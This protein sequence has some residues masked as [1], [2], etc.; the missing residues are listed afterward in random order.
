MTTV[1]VAGALA[2]KPFNG[3]N[4]WAVMNWVAGLRRLGFD[5]VFVE[6]IAP[7]SC[8]DGG[9]APAPA[10]A[11]ANLDLFRRS[12]ERFGVAGSSSLVV[13]GGPAFGL[14]RDDLAERAASAA[15]LVN[16]SGHLTDA[17][18]L[19]RVRSRAYVDLDPGYTQFWQSE[20]VAGSRLGGHDWYFTVGENIG[21]AGCPIPTGGLRWRP[22]RPPV[23]L[24]LCPV[25]S[26]GEPGRFTTV[27]SWRGAYGR[28]GHPGRL[29]GQKAHEFR[30]FL[31]LPG[32]ASQR[33]EIALEIY[34]GDE[35]DREALARNG[36]GLVD[37][38]RVAGGA[39]AFHDYVRG[40]GAEF[41]AAQGVYV[42]TGSGWFSDRTAH[43]LASGK[44]A[45]VQDTGFG[46]RYPSGEGL[47]TFTTLAGAVEGARRIAEDYGGHCRAARRIAE[48]DF[49][50]DHVLG[51]LLETVGVAP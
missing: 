29:Y 32:L 40:S 5:V 8:V 2:N 25:A 3:G 38:R 34:P 49:N 10:E 42:E 30:K 1:V 48:Q 20:G 16:I 6:Q 24:D 13:D 46:R 23:V 14:S 36:W 4:V 39:N 11:S 47:L 7:E 15:L 27:A 12:A 35:V 21:T 44:P 22:V 41:S 45:L 33:F 43:Y 17:S 50:S 28:V 9:G 19:G 18:V 26:A 51:G 31:A 37:P